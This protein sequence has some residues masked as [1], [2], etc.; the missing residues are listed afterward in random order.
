MQWRQV[1]ATQAGRGEGA[2]ARNPVV[3]DHLCK[4]CLLWLGQM[5]GTLQVEHM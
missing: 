5:T 4:A 1:R 3:L 2:R